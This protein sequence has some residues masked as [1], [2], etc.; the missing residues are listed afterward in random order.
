MI[1][2][3][4]QFGENELDKLVARNQSQVQADREAKL[5]EHR[6]NNAQQAAALRALHGA[7]IELDI[8]LRGK[9]AVI[10]QDAGDSE[11]AVIFGDYL[12][13]LTPIK[14]ANVEISGYLFPEFT[15]KTK[16][17]VEVD[18]DAF[19]AGLQEI[20]NRYSQTPHQRYQQPQQQSR[21][22]RFRERFSERLHSS[23]MPVRKAVGAVALAGLALMGGALATQGGSGDTQ[24]ITQA[25]TTATTVFEAPTTTSTITVKQPEA[26]LPI[27]LSNQET[28]D[29]LG[30]LI[31]GNEVVRQRMGPNATE[32]EIQAAQIRTLDYA[33][34][35]TAAQ[36]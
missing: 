26:A 15:T 30:Q 29:A 31:A 6:L 36:A 34:A 19:N 21:F 32:A 14:K 23:T 3:P 5:A 35:L 18:I 16:P 1:D 9:G 22:A 10:T 7:G 4:E 13:P 25:P 20:V 2:N 28:A 8:D 12:P 17:S 33:V 11:S 27:D 24:P